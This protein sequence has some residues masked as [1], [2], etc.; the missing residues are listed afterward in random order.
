MAYST[1]IDAPCID[2]PC[3]MHRCSMHRCYS[4]CIDAPCI[5]APC[6]VFVICEASA[7]QEVARRS[8]PKQ[9]GRCSHNRLTRRP[10][11]PESVTARCCTCRQRSK[12]GVRVRPREEIRARRTTLSLLLACMALE[13][14]LFPVYGV[15]V[16]VCVLGRKEREGGRLFMS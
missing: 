10:P 9:K 4:T 2:A 15:R 7:R 1:Y 8:T 11:Y 6:K 5:D 14:S 16:C 13:A 12:E 3:S